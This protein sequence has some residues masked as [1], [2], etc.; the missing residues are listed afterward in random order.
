MNMEICFALIDDNEEDIQR[1]TMHIR[2]Y[3]REKDFDV[4]IEVYQNGI[5]FLKEYKPGYDVVFLDVE[6]PH[7]DGIHTAQ[8]LREMDEHVALIFVT[9]M[10]Q[11]AIAGY[12]VSA[13]D[14]IVKPI[15]YGTFEEKLNHALWR[16][17]E[18]IKTDA[19]IF[20][21][22]GSDS[23]KKI[24]YNEIYYIT[25]DKNY[26]CY[27]TK[28]GEFRV[29]GTLREVEETFKDSLIVKCA[30]G[31][32]VNLAHIEQK[33]KNTVDIANVQFTITKPYVDSFTEAFMRY[34]RGGS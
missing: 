24:S 11:Y 28:N 10:A 34:L 7:L 18:Q 21:N 2:R 33:V 19:Y 6:M 25:K 22:V 9:R 15:R 1:L 27:V 5:D 12:E 14:F 16:V 26:I 3:A 29:R 17:D 23:Y 4:K 30:K 32:M 31:V 13:M 8:K 20:L